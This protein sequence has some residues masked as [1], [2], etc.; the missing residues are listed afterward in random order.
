MKRIVARHS[1][2]EIAKTSVGPERV[3]LNIAMAL[4]IRSGL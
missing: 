4:T 3:A 2:A 1:G